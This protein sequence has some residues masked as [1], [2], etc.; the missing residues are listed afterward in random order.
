VAGYRQFAGND[1]D[2]IVCKFSGDSTAVFSATGAPCV[3]VA[4]DQGG[5]NQDRANDLTILDDGRIA[6]AGWAAASATAGKLAIAMINPDGQLDTGF[7]SDGKMYSLDPEMKR[8]EIHA[9][10]QAGG[11]LFAVGGS[12]HADDTRFANWTLVD[13]DVGTI[14]DHNFNLLG[15]GSGPAYYR[16]VI[17][18][19][20]GMVAAVGGV[21][22]DN[23]E[24]QGAVVRI[25]ADGYPSGDG[26]WGGGDGI[27]MLDSGNQIELT[28]L[29]AQ[30]DGKL[31]VAGT[32]YPTNGTS[33]E[34]FVGRVDASGNLDLADF[35]FGFG[36]RA[37]DFQM[38][39]SF[40]IHA[41]LTLQG[42]RPVLAGSVEADGLNLGDYDFGVARLQS[43]VIFRAGF[44]AGND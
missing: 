15:S 32:R 11:Y 1:T 3:T 34:L 28:R 42:G 4:I 31:L 13:A 26:G 33:S 6:L 30:T 16:D 23:D 44:G 19:H 38:P 10:V 43:D 8:Q 41:A 35:H 14:L 37:V 17:K 36:Y 25:G 27:A 24:I 7:N 39:G 22:T 20:D 9:I 18:L 12:T 29:V 5:W 21:M 40:D 2:F